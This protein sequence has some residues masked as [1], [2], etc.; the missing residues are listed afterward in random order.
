MTDAAGRGP[1][2]AGPSAVTAAIDIGS[3]SVLLL[4]VRVGADGEARAIDEAVETTRLGTGLTTGG[5]LDGAARGRTAAAVARFAARAR[6]AGAD[7]TWAFGTGAMRDAVDGQTFAR[8]LAGTTGVPVEVLT[9]D[10]E[11]RLAYAALAHTFGSDEPILGVDLGG[12]TTELTLGTGATPRRATSVALGVVALTESVPQEGPLEAVDVA[13]LGSA[14]DA[15]FARADVLT[16]A[17]RSGARP[18]V[19]GGS[20]TAIASL[21][22]GLSAYAPHRVHGHP[23]P[24]ATLGRIVATLAAMPARARG[25]LPGLEPGR[26]AVVLAGAL[27]LARLAETLGASLTVSAQ[28]VRHGFL[29]AR[30]RAAGVQADFRRLWA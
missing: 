4:T 3:N 20:A 18:I 7:P 21:D 24:P 15:V 22:L 29:G 9:G 11:A 26:G 25:E 27:V 1:A 13:R 5:R 12:R 10:E 28:G 2:G 16:E 14:I 23:L 6:A 17:H 30:L 8:E 19:S